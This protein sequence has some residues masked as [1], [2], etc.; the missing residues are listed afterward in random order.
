V[1]GSSPAT[2]KVSLDGLADVARALPADAFH[3]ERARTFLLSLAAGDD[4]QEEQESEH[5]HEDEDEVVYEVGQVMAGPN[6]KGEYKVRWKG[7]SAQD[8]TWQS[9]GSLHTPDGED[10]EALKQYKRKHRIGAA[11]AAGN[12]ER[13]KA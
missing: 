6:Y 11:A 9:L 5:E 1:V 13:E 10:Y 7:F 4:E 12:D 8:D 2:Y 3:R